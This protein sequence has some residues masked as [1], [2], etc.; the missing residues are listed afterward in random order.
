MPGYSSTDNNVIDPTNST[1]T[2]LAAF[3]T[4]TGSFVNVTAYSSLTL[5]IK[6][7]TSSVFAGIKIEWSTDGITA[8]IAPQ[9]FTYDPA[10]TS[11]DNLT[12]HTTIRAPFYR[13]S[14]QNRNIAQTS[15]LLLVLLRKGTPTGTVRSIDPVNTFLTNIDVVTVQA[16]LSGV[17]RLN[18]EAVLLP[19]MDDNN[20]TSSNAEVYIYVSPRPPGQT[21]NIDRLSVDASL[22]PVSFALPSF[23]DRYTFFSITNNVERGNL[24]IQLGTSV[25]LS[26]DNFDFIVPPGHTWQDPAQ[27][28]SVYAGS[29]FGIW[30][31]VYIENSGFTGNAKVVAHFY[32]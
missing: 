27:F 19:S 6:S 10:V 16:I 2:P 17:G 26:T 31:E 1:T 13:I 32:G 28:G 12:V 29:I 30:D 24:F 5:V 4:Y 7:D 11:I 9:R 25:G 3:G 20:F 8:D 14:Y 21:A 23:T 15:F 18:P 22:T